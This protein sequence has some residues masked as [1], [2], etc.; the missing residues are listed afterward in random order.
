MKKKK[1][2]TILT[3]TY[4]YSKLGYASIY[5]RFCFLTVQYKDRRDSEFDELLTIIIITGITLSLWRSYKSW[6]HS[7]F[8]PM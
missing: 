2:K 4:Q 7:W 5:V 3:Y 1:E 8:N 6:F